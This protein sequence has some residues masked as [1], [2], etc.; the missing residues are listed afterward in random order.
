[1]LR[2][3]L[4][5]SCCVSTHSRPKAAARTRDAERESARF[6]SQPPEGGCLNGVTM[7]IAPR[8]FQLTAARRQLRSRKSQPVGAQKG[9]NSQPLEGGC[10]GFRDRPAPV[11][12]FNSQPPEGSCN[13]ARVGR[14]IINRFNS[15]PPEG[16][17]YRYKVTAVKDKVVSTHSRPK[18]AAKAM[19]NI[20]SIL[21]LFQLTAARRQLLSSGG[22]YG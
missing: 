9:F 17:C 13:T 8:K 18:A 21:N 4:S 7:G 3:C 11:S 15:Q 12:R 10:P 22:S 5:A 6:N 16:S 2:L 19:L 1:M 20:T 14:V